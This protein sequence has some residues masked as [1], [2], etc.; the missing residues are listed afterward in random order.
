VVENR[1]CGL[2]LPDNVAIGAS[3]G[4]AQLT[5]AK[6]PGGHRLVA[7]GGTNGAVKVACWRLDDWCERLSID[8]ELVAYVK[9]DTQGWEVQVLH[10]APRLLAHRH[11]AWQLEVSPAM[12]AAAGNSAVELYRIC[13]ERFS[14]FVDLAKGA[15]G[16]RARPVRDLED[17][18]SYLGDRAPQTDIILFNSR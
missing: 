15:K 12:L 7:G 13:A 11:I 14:H 5:H 16:P 9:V 10:G 4:T 18:L 1:L 6:Y 8:P 3:S 17:A 2:V